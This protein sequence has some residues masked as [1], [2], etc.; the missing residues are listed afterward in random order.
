MYVNVKTMPHMLRLPI[1]PNNML[2][3]NNG[4]YEIKLEK[5]TKLFVI[6]A[7]AGIGIIIGAKGTI[8]LHILTYK[9]V[10]YMKVVMV[11]ST[12]A[13]ITTFALMIYCI[14]FGIAGL[15]AGGHIFSVS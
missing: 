15:V 8:K 11:Y 3:S 7:R 10:G 14:A 6:Q 9:A 1:V 5:Y 13:L 2:R 4:F 12:F